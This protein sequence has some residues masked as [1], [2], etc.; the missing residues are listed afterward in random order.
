MP[1]LQHLTIGVSGLTNPGTSVQSS[2][3]NPRFA[4][5]QANRIATNKGD[6]TVKAIAASR[7]TAPSS[8]MTAS[9]PAKYPKVLNNVSIRF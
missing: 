1:V 5:R 8:N 2:Q 6:T 3:P 9:T 4:S 7:S